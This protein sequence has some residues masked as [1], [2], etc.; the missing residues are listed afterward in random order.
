LSLFNIVYDNT[1]NQ[2]A[3]HLL[4]KVKNQEF[5]DIYLISPYY[6]ADLSKIIKSGQEL[7]VDHLQYIL[8]DSET[9]TFHLDTNCA[10]ALNS[11]T[12]PRSSTEISSQETFSLL[13]IVK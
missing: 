7:T 1:V 12:L 6:P 3:T 8:F 5:G 10:K 4:L 2:K 9:T 13:R 11:C